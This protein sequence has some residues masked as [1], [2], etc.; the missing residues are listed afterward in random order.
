[1]QGGFDRF[2]KTGSRAVVSE[3]QVF[4]VA[5][6]DTVTVT[7]ILATVG[8][9]DPRAGR[10]TGFAGAGVGWHL[11]E[12]QSP[13]LAG[14]ADYREGHIGYHVSGGVEY[15]LAPFVWL[16]GEVQWASVPDGLGATGIGPA[17]SET[18]LGATTFRFKLIVGR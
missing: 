2:R 4:R 14:T 7:P 6:A 18:D 17:F 1:V 11:L 13:A 16:G 10:I 15:R 9:R 12:E 5:I 8:Y 3:T